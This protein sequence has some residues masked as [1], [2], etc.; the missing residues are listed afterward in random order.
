MSKGVL[1]CLAFF[2]GA[3]LALGQPPEGA[4]PTPDQAADDPHSAPLAVAPGG[5]VPGPAELAPHRALADP[6]EAVPSAP[7][8]G[9]AEAAPTEPGCARPLPFWF[10]ADYLLWWA[11][12]P[13]FPV[14]VTGGSTADPVPGALGQP[15]TQ[16][17][18]G[19]ASV[20]EHERSGGRFT[21]GTWMGAGEVWGLEANYLFLGAR[22]V[23]FSVVSTSTTGPTVLGRPFFDVLGGTQ[24]ASLVGYPGLVAGSVSVSSHSFL[25]GGEINAVAS[26]WRDS[27]W[28][29]EA[30]IGG[31]FVSLVESVDV[32]EADV[33]STT[34]TVLPGDNVVVEDHFG[35]RNYFYGPQAGV[36][37]AFHYE[38]WDL[39]VVAKVALGVTHEV[40]D[41]FGT[42]TLTPPGGPTTISNGGL[43][44]LPSNSGTFTHDSFG[45][46]PE[47]GVTLA[48]RLTH[49]L[50]VSLGY[51][52]IYWSQVMRAGDQIDTS[53]NRQQVPTS[54]LAGPVT[55][56]ARP[57]F[58]YSTTD[59]WAQGLNFGLEYHW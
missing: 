37:S 28:R 39:E 9:P 10:R 43:L 42:T 50:S 17:L 59:Y 5:T 34:S 29:C 12:D 11:K 4:L 58:P 31:R 18:F 22:D 30:L 47:L 40:A 48:Y 15:G 33:V 45:V 1:G 8:A 24:D 49:N 54:L 36:R 16:A 2:L 41:V 46:V 52:F 53:I 57:A 32:G 3:G 7:P 55:G 14:L 38:S 27:S 6:T 26:I 13:R 25:E 44:A 21:L 23:N 51:S 20:D 56:P 35:T 19:G